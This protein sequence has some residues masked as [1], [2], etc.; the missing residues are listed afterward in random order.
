MMS[1]VLVY[2]AAFFFLFAAPAAAKEGFYLGAFLPTSTLSG[3]AGTG[4]DSGSGWGVRAGLGLNRYLSVEGN[5]AVTSHDLTGG[6]STDLTGLAADLKLNFPLTS[7]DRGGV[8]TLEPYGLIGYKHYESS[9][10]STAK[11]DGVEYG[12]GIEL[13]LFRE[14]SV[15]AGW[16]RTKVT[17]KDS[18]PDTSGEVKTVDFGVIYHFL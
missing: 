16:T 12:F 2:A 18:G 10:P 11:S 15:N 8:M 9:K 4:I 5:Y 6:S 1:R 13:Y 14:L 3:D 17:F 7:L